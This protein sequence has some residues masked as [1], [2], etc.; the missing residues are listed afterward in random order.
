M[1]VETT[2]G[3]VWMNCVSF[4]YAPK[5]SSLR[6]WK[7]STSNAS[8]PKDFTTRWPWSTSAEICG[9]IG[10]ALLREVRARRDQPLKVRDGKGDDRRDQDERERQ[11]PV[12][13]D[14]RRKRRDEGR[15]RHDELRNRDAHRVDH[16]L[17]I[18]RKAR[19]Q[20]ARAPLVEL[21]EA[22]GSAAARKD[23]RAAARPDA[24][25]SRRSGTSARRSPRSRATS[26]TEVMPKE[27]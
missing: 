17:Q 25:R 3:C 19:D 14:H 20:L 15:E 12:E 6:R 13:V 27:R 1:I 4:M 2:S 7:R 16:H 11:Q 21:P 9:E 8:R 5:K 18:G 10:D 23:A 24:A 26:A 22:A